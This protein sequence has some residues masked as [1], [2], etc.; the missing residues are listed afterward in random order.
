MRVHLDKKLSDGMAITFF[1]IT[2]LTVIAFAILL[3]RLGRLR[4]NARR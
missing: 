4:A 1:V 3:T 2:L